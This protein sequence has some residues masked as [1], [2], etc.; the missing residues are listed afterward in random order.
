MSTHLAVLYIH[1]MEVIVYCIVAVVYLAYHNGCMH[2]LPHSLVD[3]H[4]CCDGQE[5]DIIHFLGR[6][7]HHSCCKR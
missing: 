3:L 2:L 4:S 1:H 5:F 6:G 7:I